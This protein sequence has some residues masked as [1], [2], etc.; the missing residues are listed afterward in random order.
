MPVIVT[1]VVKPFVL[2]DVK[3]ALQ[4]RGV[5][6]LTVSTVHGFGRQGGHTDVYRGVEY[7]VDLVP[8]V[9]LEL[10]VEDAMVDEVVEALIAAARTGKI[11]DGKVW[12]RPVTE[13]VRV[14]TGQRGTDAL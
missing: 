9:E 12:L 1:A 14:R 3:E 6:G 13:V 8:K 7:V 5:P 10:V 11:G 2:E 4:A